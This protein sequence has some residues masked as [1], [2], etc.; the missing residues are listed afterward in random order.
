MNR[1]H[2]RRPKVMSA[3]T[4]T[5]FAIAGGTGNIGAFITAALVAQGAR[6]V[7]ILSRRDIEA[8]AGTTAIKVDYENK[9][10]LVRALTD[11]EVVVSA[12]SGVEET[13]T[14]FALADGA[15]KEAGAKLFVPS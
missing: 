9:A 4:H 6:V 15:A 7:R 3:L 10:S 5:T 14:Q 11:T 2:K 8:P 12:V 1:R 13:K